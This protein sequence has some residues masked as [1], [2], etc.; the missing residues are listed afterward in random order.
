MFT[1]ILH[2]PALAIVISLII[3][4]LGT[5]SIVTL[6]ISQFPDVAPVVVMVTLDYPGASAKV[7]EESCLIPLE[8]SINGVPDMKYMTSDAT[9]AGEATIQVIFHMGTDPN[10]ATVNVMNRVNQVMSRLPPLVQREGII[11]MNLTPNMLMF[12]NL[13]S[14]DKNADMKFLFNYGYINLVPE[15]Q[16]TRGVGFVKILGTRQYAMRIW[17]KPDRMRAY[18]VA[19]EEVM[20]ALKE[21]SMIGSPGRIGRADSK[22][23]QSLEYVLT[24]IGRYN[25]AEQYENVILRATEKGELLRLKDVASVELGSEFYDL[26]SDI[27]GH[28]SAAIVIKQSFG[29]NAHEVIKELK[30]KLGEF[31]KDMFP[32]GMDYEISYDVSNFLDASIEQVLH[33]LIEAFVLV[34]LVVF[35][36]LGDWRSTLI[37]T[38]AVPVSL[39]GAFF[40]M[41]QFGVTINLITLFAL[42]LAIGI[43][44]DDPIVVVEAVHAKMHGTDMSPYRAT[45]MVLHEISGAVIAITL[46]MTAVFVPVT[47]MSGPVGVFYRQF[48]ITM[49]VAIVLSGVMALSL[50]P[51][52]CAMILRKPDHHHSPKGPIGWLLHGFN[53]VFEKVTDIYVA[54]LKR[55]VHRR[56]LTFGV[57]GAAAAAIYFINQQLAAGF[58]PAEDQG[59]IYAILQTPP[60]STLERTYQKSVELEKIAKQIEGVTSVTSLA[61]YEVLTEGRGS[62]AGTCLIN[63]K[64]WSERKKTAPEIIAELEEKCKEIAGVN[65]EF[66]EPPAVPGYGAA[67]GISFRMLDKTNTG[68]YDR[69]QVVTN[70]FMEALLKRKELRGVFTFFS[71]AYPQQEIIIDNK[72]AMQKGVS[73]GKA[74]DNLGI[75]IGSTYEQGFIKFGQFFKLYVQA[76]PKYRKLPKD[77]QDLY[78]AND[79]GEMVP[80]SAFM[81]LVPKQGLNEITRY[82]VYP[83]PTIQ[84]APADGYSSGDAIKAIEAAAKEVLPRGFGIG[85]LG[86]SFDEV[87]RGNESIYIFIIVLAFVYMV[88]VGQYESFTLPMAVI[89]SLPIGVMGS[90][91]LL[92]GM[93][94]NNDIYAQVGIIMLVGLLGKNAILIVEFAQQRHQEGLSILEAAIEGARVRLRPIL[95]TSF[96]F[97]AGMVPLLRA[98]GAGAIANK[99]IG[100]SAAGGMFLGTMMGLLVVPGLYYIFGTIA[101]RGKLLPDESETP[102]SE[103]GEYD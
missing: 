57:L 2:R 47:F 99:T 63:L 94:L 86:L 26:Y 32:P 22:T 96:A 97:I 23:S 69:L 65:L 67:G 88:L 48:S 84:C 89:L 20:E 78:V 52:L 56:I 80:Y 90:F 58:I 34:A 51:V 102:L 25:E 30:E 103:R 41:Q 60:G 16:R 100:A 81:K 18:N 83:A 55:I 101:S 13:Y 28:P 24:Y 43:V 93:G 11:V 75:M 45:Q 9:S 74:M 1:K 37:P 8:R 91:L 87:A 59:M 64:N 14:T 42:V 12:V 17:L 54:L 5:L 39:V 4:F 33:T 46:V 61:G 7:L 53:I 21:Q 49:A 6:P 76:E 10:Q 44:V 29:T 19:T 70:E 3:L 73:I 79:R 40:L 66:Y 31:K 35:V 95:M 82:N 38:L 72:V 71:S 85:W 36:F 68:D 98:H 50:T 15:L 77:L 62:N 92:K 27:D